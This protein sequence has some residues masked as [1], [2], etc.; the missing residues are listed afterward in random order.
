MIYLLGFIIII[1]LFFLKFIGI[2]LGETVF[3]IVEL[4]GGIML[5]GGACEAFVI[6]I[7]SIA[8]NF[9]MTDYVSGIYASLAST[10]PELSVIVF[11]LIGG[12]YEMAW[13]LALATIFMNS[14][15]FAV[16]TLLLP[17]DERGN[18]KLPDAIRIWH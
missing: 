5:I 11:L 17:K 16:Y 1:G 8:H 12:Q 9:K 10:I 7:E 15:V 14:L 18:F 3:A 13:V 4:L 2:H 6:S